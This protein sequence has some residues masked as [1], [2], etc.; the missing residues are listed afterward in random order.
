MPREAEVARAWPLLGAGAVVELLA[1]SGVLP[2]HPDLVRALSL[3]PLDLTFDLGTLLSRATGPAWFALGLVLAITVRAT[4]LSL[5]L[6]S[7]RR[8]WFALRFEL[9]VL[10]PSFLAA[11]LTYSG[12]SVLYSAL[13]WVGVAVAV[14]S[15]LVFAHVPWRGSPSVL[16]TTGSGLFGGPRL[17][18]V[19]SYLAALGVLGALVRGGGQASPLIGVVVSVVLTV[20]AARRLSRPPVAPMATRSAAVV[21]AAVLV[22]LSLTTTRVRPPH[23][24]QRPGELVVVAG[25]DTSSGHGSLFSLRPAYFGFSCAH[26]L[27]YSYMGAGRGT[28]QGQAACPITT[29]SRYTRA[30][31]E[32]PL[33]E[34]VSSFRAQI[35]HLAPPVTVV[36]HSS[37]AW[38]A[39]AAV[40]GDRTTPVRRIVMLAPLSD[41]HGYPPPGTNG[42]GT[43]GA[44]GMRLVVAIANWE[45]FSHFDPDRPLATALLGSPS[46]A[47]ALFERP[48]PQRLRALAVPSAYD[49]VLSSSSDPFGRAQTACALFRSHGA[50]AMS[51]AAAADADRFLSGS[52]QLPCARWP[53]WAADAASAFQV[54]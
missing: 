21:L 25:I 34:L 29:G 28:P 33:P 23:P 53:S 36:T 4:I 13:F 26:T 40:S 39:W 52:P 6:G 8:W 19:L 49:L 47:R 3:P 1:L 31:T 32:R 9:M 15:T 42:A 20:A 38:V 46:A 22:A 2:V 17:P 54:P 48:L 7:L 5:L 43:L 51:A 30:D 35:D 45:G 44:A 41:P 18:T 14:A 11:E 16:S 37:G 10:V 12:Q 27:Y 24:A 50:V